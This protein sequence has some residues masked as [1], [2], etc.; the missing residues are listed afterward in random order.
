VLNLADAPYFPAVQ[1][2]LAGDALAKGAAV[3][4][5]LAR[6]G[7]LAYEGALEASRSEEMAAAWTPGFRHRGDWSVGLSLRAGA[8]QDRDNILGVRSASGDAAAPAAATLADAPKFGDYIALHFGDGAGT[9]GEI[10]ADW[11]ASLGEDEE[12]WDFSIENAGTGET[13]ALLSP[14]GLE[15]LAAAGL[16]A[17]LVK[18]GEARAVE[19]GESVALA[20]EG[21][22][23]WYSLVVTPHADF[24]SRLKGSFS[25]SQNFP[26]PVRDV[27][28]FRF[29]LPQ[30]WDAD[31]KRVS[32]N[33]PLRLNVYDYQGRRVGEVASGRFRAG[34]HALTWKPASKD[35][36]PLAKG[37]YIYRLELPNFTKSLN[38]L[39][40]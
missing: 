10:A 2:G 14:A 40:E 15:G 21:G 17:F 28:T 12:W 23:S 8:Y 13:Q 22:K 5:T 3:G 36:T 29:V 39:V 26:N 6:G 34:S 27:T 7:S 30:T 37:A 18:Q 11:R 38:L 4:A 1:P 24:A 19:P 9:A 31:G 35:G 33:F 25:I 20:L 32:G 16:K